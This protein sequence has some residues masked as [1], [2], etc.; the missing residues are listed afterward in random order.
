MV[1]TIVPVVDGC[2][3]ER[4]PSG[5]SPRWKLAAIHAAGAGLAAA[6]VGACMAALAGTVGAPWGWVGSAV[7]AAAAAGYA[8]R[9]LVRLPVP[10]PHRKA[11]VPEWWRAF[12]AP[13]TAVFLY[14]LGLG[15]G[16]ITHLRHG[17]YLVVLLAAS[18]S[19]DPFTGALLCLPYGL[20]RGFSPALACARRQKAEQGLLRI[21]RLERTPIPR[22]THGVTLAL[23]T[24]AAS[25]AAI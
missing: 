22:L 8:A 5:S 25:T 15:V 12:F 16:V 18:L 1:E 13:P 7:V 19:G 3:I 11:Q 4:P 10:V 9:E 24:A 14:G 21:E 23:L 17:T 6:L 2:E 20:A